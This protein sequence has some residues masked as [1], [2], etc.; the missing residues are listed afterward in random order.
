TDP[1]DPLLAQVCLAYRSAFYHQLIAR[2]L[3]RALVANADILVSFNAPPSP[4]TARAAAT[5]G[6]PFSCCVRLLDD[7]EKEHSHTV[8]AHCAPHDP[9]LERRSTR[10]FRLAPPK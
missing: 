4:V 5:Y 3:E 1:Q 7:R 2:N 8:V 9:R 6:P 10:P